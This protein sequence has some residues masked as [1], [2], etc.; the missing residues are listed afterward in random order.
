LREI[1]YVPPDSKLTPGERL[2]KARTELRLT[3]DDI[4]SAVGVTRNA[5]SLWE[6]DASLPKGA[7]LERVAHAVGRSLQWL[8]TGID[9][10]SESEIRD[11]I[12]KALEYALDLD[13]REISP[14]KRHDLITSTWD[15]VAG[16]YGLAVPKQIGRQSKK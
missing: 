13:E 3:Q 10:E 2:R 1:N 12:I 4:A 16:I 15:H 6:S 5:V 11:I 7:R 9:S 14:G 8:M